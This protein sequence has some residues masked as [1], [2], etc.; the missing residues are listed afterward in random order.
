[1][2]D[3]SDW[4]LHVAMVIFQP[5]SGSVLALAALSVYSSGL[6]ACWSQLLRGNPVA[7]PCLWSFSRIPRTPPTIPCLQSISLKTDG[8]IA[9]SLWIY[10]T[11]SFPHPNLSL[12]LA[13]ASMNKILQK[14]N[15]WL[16]PP[17]TFFL[18]KPVVHALTEVG[19]K[20]GRKTRQR[21]NKTSTHKG[22]GY[23]T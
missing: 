8:T 21:I 5:D 12:S 20:A 10:S 19:W 22:E 11:G 4:E 7:L 16:F 2:T 9:C 6:H 15:H 1:M 14:F 13:E 23:R 3:G 17:S 18:R